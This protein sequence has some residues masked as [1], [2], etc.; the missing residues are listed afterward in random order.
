MSIFGNEKISR[1]QRVWRKGRLSKM[2]EGKPIEKK[3][4]SLKRGVDA[5]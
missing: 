1:F 5:D 3:Q 2:V 4:A